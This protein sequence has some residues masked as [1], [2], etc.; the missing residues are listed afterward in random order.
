MNYFNYFSRMSISDELDEKQIDSVISELQQRIKNTEE[1]KQYYIDQI[2]SCSDNLKEV[3]ERSDQAK[4]LIKLLENKKST[5][6]EKD[7]KDDE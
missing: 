3:I 1:N 7:N 2:T 6:K 4:K 5:D